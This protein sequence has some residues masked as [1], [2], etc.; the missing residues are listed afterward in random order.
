MDDRQLTE[1]EMRQLESQTPAPTEL[2]SP[3]PAPAVP[4]K[5]PP[6]PH[7]PSANSARPND[8]ESMPPPSTISQGAL[9]R[10]VR[11]VM[12]PNAK[13][14]YKVSADIRQMWQDGKK[15]KVF[16]LFA[17]CGNDVDVFIKRYSIKK[18]QEKE[19]EVGVFF[20]FQ[21]EAELADK[22][23]RLRSK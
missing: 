5:N 21:T 10:R 15:D 19:F 16:K 4:A 8:S 11:R 7:A 3:S 22:P 18:D 12:E 13:G 9:D 1:E 6:Q 14:Q 17:N 23:E 20:K 2:D